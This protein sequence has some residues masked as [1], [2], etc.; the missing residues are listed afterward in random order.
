MRECCDASVQ[1]PD[2]DY[3]VF[4]AL[5]DYLLTDE[6]AEAELTVVAVLELMMLANAYGVLRLEQLCEQSV[7]ENLA[8]S[9]VDE[10]R[11]CAMLIG[12][13]RLE[14]AA[15]VCRRERRVRGEAARW[16]WARERLYGSRSLG[17]E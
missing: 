8:E 17:A 9:K 3:T 12:S 7:S 6:L 13:A 4:R 11:S 5:L 15:E 10:V 14:R 1:I 16:P 2:V